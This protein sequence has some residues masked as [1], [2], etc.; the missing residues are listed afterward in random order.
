MTK[1]ASLAS[2]KKHL[3]RNVAIEIRNSLASTSYSSSRASLIDATP[4]YFLPQSPAPPSIIAQELN[5]EAIRRDFPALHQQINGHPL[6]WLDNAATTQKPQCVMDAITRFYAQDNSNVHRGAHTLAKRATDAYEGAREKIMNF[7]GASSTDEIVFL[8]GATEGINLVA[9]SYGRMVVNPDDEVVVSTLDHH[10]NIV[11]WQMLCK[12]KGAILRVIPITEHG[13][14]MI[15]EYERLL[16]TKTR[17][18]ALP[19][20]SNALGTVL[21]IKRLIDIAHNHGIP[22]LIDGAQGL[23]H[24]KTNV[25][26][27]G[28]DFYV[29]SG[30]KLFGPTGIGVLYGKKQLLEKMPPWQGGGNM[31]KH[32][33]F[34]DTT[35]NS[36]PNKF[37]AGTGHI[38]G[39]VGLGAAIDYLIGI[40]SS[41]I[42]LYENKLL[43][44]ATEK[45]GNIPKLRLIGTA[46][47]KAGVLSFVVPGTDSPKISELLDRQGIAV[48]VGHHC[49]QPSLQHFGLDHTIRPS[50][51]F[52]NT[53]AEIDKLVW[54]IEQSIH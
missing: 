39:A 43:S 16:T 17:L 44:Y 38:A 49:A 41:K 14:I 28:A 37:E 19:H 48:R 53:F 23:P 1:E 7:L 3:Q 34:E 8:R 22:V 2:V 54:T 6:I 27:L 31:I 21:P 24:F 20:V 40:G 30:H 9:Q 11:P 5:V 36:L 45:L 52:Y 51:A 47:H 35:F 29:F 15:E 18:I 10:A 42:E 12:E 46:A 25:Q 26:E 4:Y 32:V 13:E 50:I 33:T